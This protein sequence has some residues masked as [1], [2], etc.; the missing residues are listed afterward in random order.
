MKI[1]YRNRCQST[2]TT[3]KWI[4]LVNLTGLMEQHRV[5]W[6][7]AL[8]VFPSTYMVCPKYVWGSYED[9]LLRGTN[10]WYCHTHID[11]CPI[12][13]T[14]DCLF[15][16]FGIRVINS[17]EQ[18]GLEESK[19]HGVAGHCTTGFSLW[20]KVY[21]LDSELWFSSEWTIFVLFIT[22]NPTSEQPLSAHSQSPFKPSWMFR[23]CSTALTGVFV[24]SKTFPILRKVHLQ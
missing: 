14:S 8:N 4:L 10:F 19:G 17:H 6:A 11:D 20:Y 7:W 9:L 23:D 22:L 16:N 18:L 2:G 15:L 1:M 24:P 5:N 12:S 3:T 13:L 21:I